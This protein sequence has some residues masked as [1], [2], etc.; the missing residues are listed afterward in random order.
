MVAKTC[1]DIYAKKEIE[2]RNAKVEEGGEKSSIFEGETRS[3]AK[4]VITTGPSM[5]SLSLRRALG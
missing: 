1:K 3:K 4:E 2:S 5:A